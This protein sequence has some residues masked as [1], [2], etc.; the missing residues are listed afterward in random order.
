MIIYTY[1]LSQGI[2]KYMH[3]DDIVVVNYGYV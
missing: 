1:K 3:V 2:R